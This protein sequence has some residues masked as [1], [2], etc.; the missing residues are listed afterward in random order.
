MGLGRIQRALTAAVLDESSF[1]DTIRSLKSMEAMLDH[2]SIKETKRQ[3][4]P[5]V[6]E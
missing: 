3:N 5:S 1:I 4:Q 2:R 6:K